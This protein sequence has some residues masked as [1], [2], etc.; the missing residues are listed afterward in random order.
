LDW[1][2]NVTEPS[3]FCKA[4]CAAG[5]IKTRKQHRPK[6]YEFCQTV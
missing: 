6:A 4:F 2:Y 1:F 3:G 5:L